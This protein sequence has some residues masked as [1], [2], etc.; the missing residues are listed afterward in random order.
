MNLNLV[1]EKFNSISQMMDILDK[2]PNNKI[3]QYEH[4]SSHEGDKDWY[5]TES[6]EEASQLMRTGYTEILPKIKEGLNKS[7]KVVSKM[8][9]ATDLRRPKNLP[10][11]FI[12]NIPN[13]ILGL[14]DS[15]IDIKITPQK[16]KTLSIVYVMS[17]HCRNTIEMWIQA[18]IALLTAIKIVERQGISVSID[19]SFYCGCNDDECAMGSVRV[20]HFGQ[21]MDLQKLCFPMANPSMFRRIGFKFLETT[22]VITKSG[23]QYGYGTG[24]DCYED[25]IKKMI[26]N[27]KTFVL[28]GQWIQKHDYKVEEILKYL[29]FSKNG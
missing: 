21:P 15:M 23:F 27:D 25:E 14:P 7:A 22:P 17:G 6:Y 4:S 12:P 13:A 2:R 24:F 1:S 19:C 18:G 28:S 8:F 29:N 26:E 20:K 11:G 3:M 9:A 16:R 5:G 10:V